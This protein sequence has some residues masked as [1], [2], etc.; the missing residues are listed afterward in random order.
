MNW[1]S[2]IAASNLSAALAY[3]NGSPLQASKYSEKDISTSRRASKERAKV[4]KSTSVLYMAPHR[5]CY[6]KK[7]LLQLD[8]HQL[9]S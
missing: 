4:L 3:I 1:G 7:R 5:G 2:P 9:Y 6:C 8:K